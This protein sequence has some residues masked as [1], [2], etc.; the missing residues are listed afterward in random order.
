[1]KARSSTKGRL[2]RGVVNGEFYFGFGRSNSDSDEPVWGPICFA[3]LRVSP[4]LLLGILCHP[5]K[6]IQKYRS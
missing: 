4:E 2:R 5:S 6:F 1:M 3:V